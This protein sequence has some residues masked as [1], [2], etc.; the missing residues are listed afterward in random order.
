M[1]KK[2]V[3]LYKKQ[4]KDMTLISCANVVTERF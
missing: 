4:R 1:D 3:Y 2:K